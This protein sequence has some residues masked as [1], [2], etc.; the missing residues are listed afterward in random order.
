MVKVS[1][2]RKKLLKALTYERVNGKPIYY[3]N[4][5]K[6]L[7]GE[8][9]L[10]A[11]MGSSE[12]QAFLLILIASYLRE[13]LGRDYLVLGGEL[14]FVYSSKSF[15]SLDIAIYRKTDLPQLSGK[16]TRKPPLVVIEIDTKA[17]LKNYGS[18]EEYMYEKTQDLLNAG[19]EKVIWFTTR[20]KKVLIAERDKDWITTDWDNDIE[21]LNG[22]VLNLQKLLKEEGF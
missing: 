3:R 7:K 11:V 19:V 5:E 17:S 12:I 1:E 16:Y 9:P 14:G 18:F 21:V 22:V 20:V 4:Y 13:K 2:D 15:R 8:L 10:E 6:V